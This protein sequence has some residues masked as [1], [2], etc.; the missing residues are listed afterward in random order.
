MEEDE[1]ALGGLNEQE[2]RALYDKPKRCSASRG[3]GQKL[4]K[5]VKHYRSR[6]RPKP[7]DVKTLFPGRSSREVAEELAEHFN[8]ISAEF[9]PLETHQIPVTRPR[10]LPVF[11][12]H[13]VAGRMRAF[14]K[15]IPWLRAIFFPHWSPAS[16]IF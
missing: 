10:R 11:L 7:F 4:F 8:K 12:P 2:K 1:E 16:E 15:P 5:N 3:W 9:Q 13:E 6:E 14:K